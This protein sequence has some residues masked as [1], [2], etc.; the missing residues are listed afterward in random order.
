MGLLPQG[1]QPLFLAGQVLHN[2]LIIDDVITL[3][4]RG[5]IATAS[6]QYMHV[7]AIGIF[8]E[9]KWHVM[10]ICLSREKNSWG[11]IELGSPLETI[12]VAN[13][14]PLS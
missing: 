11:L 5:K 13:A 8:E 4:L 3:L 6:F 9:S 10:Q 2:V 1:Y 14:L 12:Y 7:D